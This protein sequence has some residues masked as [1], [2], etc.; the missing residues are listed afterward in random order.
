MN[1]T[2]PQNVLVQGIKTCIS[3]KV[4][5]MDANL[6]YEPRF[7]PHPKQVDHNTQVIVQLDTAE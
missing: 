4:Y 2:D 3:I 1:R 6:S 7:G 5:I